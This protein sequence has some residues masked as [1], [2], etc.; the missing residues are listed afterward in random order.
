M[1]SHPHPRRKLARRYHPDKN[2]AGR[3]RFVAVQRAYERLQAGAAAGQG[4]QPWRLLLIL[5]VRRCPVCLHHIALTRGASHAHAW[6]LAAECRGAA[7]AATHVLI[8]SSVACKHRRTLMF[9]QPRAHLAGWST[10]VLQQCEAAASIAWP[11]LASPQWLRT[12][13]PPH[14]HPDV[15][16]DAWRHGGVRDQDAL[17]LCC[18]GAMHPVQALP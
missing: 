3:E 7:A 5:K 14:V 8:T 4:P 13:L 11:H 17:P 6:A 12:K 2:P 1:T 10:P 16:Q 18:A 15:S 9:S